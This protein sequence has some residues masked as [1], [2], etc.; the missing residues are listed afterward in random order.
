M[1]GGGAVFDGEGYSVIRVATQGEVG[2]AA[3]VELGGTAQRLTG[4]H[5]AGALPG[6]MDEDDGEAMAALQVALV[7]EQRATSP[8]TFSSMRC[9]RPNGSR[10]SIRGFNLAT[11]CSSFA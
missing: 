4:A 7:G 6:V 8:L 3:G 5:G 2:I 11:V 10:T 9:P 1:A